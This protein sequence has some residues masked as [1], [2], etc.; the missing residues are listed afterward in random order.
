M[1]H[2]S[3]S[4]DPEKIH[5]SDRHSAPVS[6]LGRVFG[7]RYVSPRAPTSRSL[8]RPHQP[9]YRDEA[10]PAVSGFP[11]QMGNRVAGNSRTIYR[12]NE[13]WPASRETSPGS[14]QAN[15]SG[16]KQYRPSEDRPESLENSQVSNQE[17]RENRAH[18]KE[19]NEKRSRIREHLP[20]H[21]YSNLEKRVSRSGRKKYRPNED[22]PE[23]P[24]SSQGSNQELRENKVNSQER[25]QDWAG[26]EEQFPQRNEDW[27]GSRATSRPSNT[28]RSR[29]V[30]KSSGKPSG[31]A[32]AVD[33]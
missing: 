33:W 23:S 1:R 11:P 4:S 17:W 2:L 21:A 3:T 16:R 26:G 32:A 25:K 27:R 13:D 6:P 9:E 31:E 8:N 18:S 10:P 20:D 22:W 5:P 24:E 30:S 12:P 19:N 7:V 15:R 28:P 14:N 29:A